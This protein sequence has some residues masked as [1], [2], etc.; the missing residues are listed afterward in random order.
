MTYK[1]LVFAALGD[2]CDPPAVG[3]PGRRGIGRI[4]RG[5]SARL[6]A[7]DIDEPKIG[8]ALILVDRP[9]LHGEYNRAAVG[10]KRRSAQPFHG[11]QVLGSHGAL[12]GRLSLCGNEQC[13]ENGSS[14][15]AIHASSLMVK[16]QVRLSQSTV[17]MPKRCYLSWLKSR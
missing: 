3:A 2:E 13:D 15:T 4:S 16:V 17:S 5:Q 10:R 12:F 8:F 9:F 6:A 1:A 14:N 7:R 11:P